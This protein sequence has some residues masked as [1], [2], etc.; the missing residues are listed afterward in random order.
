MSSL[1]EFKAYILI[2]VILAIVIVIVSVSFMI[3]L[4]RTMK[5]LD[6]NFHIFHFP[7]MQGYIL[8]LCCDKTTPMT[9]TSHN[10][11]SKYLTLAGSD[12]PTSSLP[13][14]PIFV[15]AH[16]TGNHSN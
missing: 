8:L 6:A 3:K 2:S 13:H 4:F 15:Q 9:T 11:S 5:I 10:Q 12:K 7:H 16:V 1:Q 14:R